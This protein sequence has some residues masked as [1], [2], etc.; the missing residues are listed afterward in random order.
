MTPTDIS[1][2][3]THDL[4]IEARQFTLKLE[5]D[6]AQ[7]GIINLTITQ[8]VNTS[9][10]DGAVILLSESPITVENYPKDGTRYVPRPQWSSQPDNSASFISK[11]Q[12]VGAFYKTL[13]VDFPPPTG[14]STTSTSTGLPETQKSFTISVSGTNP[15][16]IYYASVHAASSVLQYYPI[17]VQS[18]PLEGSMLE[19]GS[20]VYA[21]NIPSLPAAPLAPVDG[22]VYH[23]QQLNLIQYYHG[24]SGT[25]V[26]TRSDTIPSGPYNPG[27]IGQVYLYAA[28]QLM[29]FNGL[30]WVQASTSNMQV[31]AHVGSSTPWLPFSRISSQTRAPE[32]PL[33]GEFF[34]DYTLERVT[35]WNGAEWTFPSPTNVLFNTGTSQVQAF[36]TPLTVEPELLRDPYIGQLFYNTTTQDLNVW[37]GTSWQKANTDQVGAPSTDKLQIGNDGS[38]EERARLIKVLNA[39]LGWPQLCV[40]L[41]E[42]QFNIAIDNAIENYRQLSSNAYTR[43]FILFKLIPNQ[44]LYFLNNAVDKTDHIVDIHKIHRLGPLGVHGAGP[45]DVWAHA[46]AQ[47]FYDLAAGGADLLSTHLVSAYGEEL[48]RL[49]AGD[50]AFQWSEASRELFITRAVRGNEVVIIEAML[51]R[52]E[53][54]IM[55]D[56][57]AKQYIQNWALAELKMMLGMIRSKYSSGTP[58]PGGTITLNGELLIAE[59]RQDMTELKEELLN[60]EYGGLV[61]Q[62]NVSFLWA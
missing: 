32:N 45:N 24:S 6:P 42:E 1:T 14:L 33:P 53:Q 35:F 61:G 44:Q 54:E 62:G 18:Y 11:A 3:T 56:R 47:R 30:K 52:S 36:V 50:L 28:N 48:E 17:G 27:V 40:E 60:Y 38:Y 55:L 21:G 46:F 23:D 8:P 10:V 9:V 39:Q 26:P 4:W 37:N 59:A 15:S 41:Q 29:V 34:Y 16:K 5:R 2:R 7:P 25:W 12:V 22:M 13:G 31:R 43:G 58:G 57:W 51:E 20:G 19:R 49:F